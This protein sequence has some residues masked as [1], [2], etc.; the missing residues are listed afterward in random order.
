ME[1]TLGKSYEPKTFETELYQLWMKEGCFDAAD[2]NVPGQEAFSIVIPPPNVTGVLHMG[3]ALTNTIQDILTRWHRMKG[4]NTLWLPGTDHAGI[5][6]QAQVEKAIAKEGKGPSGKPLTRHDMGREAFLS[7][8]WKW[9]EEHGSQITNQLK[10]LGSSLDWSRE[11]F[12]M[13]EGLSSAVREVFVRLYEEGLI[14]RGER[15]INWCPR[16][17]TA[18]SDLEVIPTDRKGFFW[19]LVYKIVNDDGT[20]VLVDGQPAQLVIATTR[21]ETLLGDT[22]VAVHPDDERYKAFHGKQAVLPLLG[23]QIPVIT[24][25]Y[26]DR[27]FGSGALKVTPAHDFNDYELGKKH[28]LPIISVMG[29]NGMITAAGGPYAGL[30]F[31]EARERVIG[32]LKESGL[33]VK[34]ED[35][36]HKVGLC[37]RCEQV[38]EPIISK[39]W[40][41]KIEP[42]AKPAI[43]AVETGKI[44]FT[45]KSWE[46]TYFE[47]MYN[48]RDWC[49]SRQ[50]WWGH[51][52]PAWYC[53]RCQQVTVARETPQGCSACNAPSSDLKRDEDVLDTW[54]SSALWPFST[55]GWPEKTEALKTFYPTSILETGFDIIFFWVARMIMMGIHFMGDVPFHK[56]Y[57]HA[58]VRDEKGEKM[59]KSKGNVID[60]LVLIDQHGADPLRFTLAAMAGQGRDIKLSVDRV[61]GYR[62]FCNK[63]WNATKFFHMQM[64]AA[65]ERGE[66]IEQPEGGVEKWV[67]THHHELSQANRWILSRL[68]ALIPRVEKGLENFELNESAQALYEFTWHELC[69]WYIELSKLPFRE[70]GTSARDCLYVLRYVFEI[71]FRVMHPFMPFVTEELW[72]SLPWRTPANTPAR[73]RDGK[74]PVMTLMFQKFPAATPAFQDVDSERTIG[75]LKAVVEAI[76]NFRG[77]NGISPKVEFA[78]RY[79]P[80]SAAAHAVVQMLASD[81]KALARITALERIGDQAKAELDAVIPLSHPPVELRISL[82]GLVNVEEETKRLQ[83]EIEKVNGD[84]EFVQKKLS[85]ETFI[86]K[87]PRELVEKERRREQELI[88]KRTELQGALARLKKI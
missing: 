3:H 17:Q 75:A 30:K 57:L 85:Q 42:L 67:T 68:N 72:L 78:V 62:A 52:I 86:A 8:T 32:D 28:N 66:K 58:M 77:E 53:G 65:R 61:E 10:R 22:A 16:C 20:P 55:L 40:F 41:V 35:H 80:Q 49:I 81:I 12:T 76:R 45:P 18:L 2:R 11:R 46:K 84:V 60:P 47:W 14:Y 69:D 5:A 19:H 31:S 24:D 71:L 73:T 33:L 88:G 7:R 38:A 83:K 48:I 25:S 59:S 13:D 23:R 15:I 56:V 87:A 1:K 82:Q 79:R 44:T 21:P 6:T 43:A 74:P 51:Q 54:F 26:V 63:L 39:Q 9:K 36:S 4:D 34:T 29:K 37:Q 70:G 27:E 64:D 50:L